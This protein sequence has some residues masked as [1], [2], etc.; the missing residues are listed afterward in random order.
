M[1]GERK[2]I[3]WTAVGA[4]AAVV[5]ALLTAW[6]LWHAYARESA[7]LVSPPSQA[8][9]QDGVLPAKEFV[10]LGDGLPTLI[11]FRNDGGQEALVKQVILSDWKWV[12][13]PHRRN[14]AGAGKTVR[15]AFE[16]RHY[17]ENTGQYTLAL[18]DPAPAPGGG[19]WTTL[20]VAVIDPALVGKTFVGRVTVI[21]DGMDQLHF[22]NVEI[23][24][25]KRVSQPK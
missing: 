8:V 2:N 24:V 12:P 15:V 4:V 6:G 21:S 11:P 19:Q 16:R 1:E 9:P 18:R 23:D 22:D 14:I 25:V 10:P 17:D 3:N 13:T 20:E 5:V 7:K